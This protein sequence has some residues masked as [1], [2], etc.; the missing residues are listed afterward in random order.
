MRLRLDPFLLALLGV[1]L[2]GTFLPVTGEGLDVLDVVV[3]A[4]VALLFF[5]YGV[6]L[7]PAETWHGLRGWRLH[8]A[9]LAMTYVAFPLMGLLAQAATEPVL[10]AG[11]ATGVLLLTLVP[12]TVQSSVAF[13]AIARGNVAGAVVGA[14]LSNLLGVALT[15]LLVGLL[16]A[17]SGEVT[18]SGSTV[19]SIVLQLLVPFALGTLSRPLT[20]ATVKRWHPVL[21][22]YDRLTIL[23]VVY[24]AF[25][26]GAEADVWSHVDVA[27]ALVVV[28]V[29]AALLAA[30]LGLCVLLGRAI[31]LAP[32][33]RAPLLFCGSHKSLAAGLPMLSVLFAS[34]DFALAVL[35]LMLFHQLQLVVCAWLAGRMGR[36]A[37]AAEGA[38]TQ[39]A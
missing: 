32:A 4:A 26:K 14:S 1:A 17:G 39:D 29:C 7:S 15:P 12:S 28:A 19:L 30:A 6:R 10:P 21:S 38:E 24:A 16:L 8:V 31:R 33:D 35:P 22:R 5:L 25:S 18:V 3:K 36:R 13:T 37:E 27:S 9:I 34:D 2:L 11:L 20:A 23:L